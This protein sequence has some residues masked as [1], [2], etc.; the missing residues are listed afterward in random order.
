MIRV[1]KP[2]IAPRSLNRGVAA[3]TA[4]CA[5]FDADSLLFIDGY[6]SFEFD[7][8][9]YGHASV[10]TALETAQHGK[11]CYCENKFRAAA[12]GDVEH[13]R[14]KKGARQDK[15]HPIEHSGYYW[16]AYAWSNLYFSCLI[17]NRSG[18]KGFFPLADSTK[19]AR[20]HHDNI[21]D[22]QPLL[23]DPGGRDDPRDHI[24]FHGAIAKGV[25]RS[26]QQTVKTLKLNRAALEEARLTRIEHLRAL[27]T[28]IKL[29][30]ESPLAKNAQY[31]K[32]ARR[33]LEDAVK[34]DAI[35]SAMAQDFLRGFP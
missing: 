13:F 8:V 7:R 4:D 6:K 16:L 32:D 29:F 18:K 31:A 11:C 15:G 35:F 34:P 19:R 23:L 30:E 22:E 28:I 10:K 3:T 27:T 1:K 24:H 25:T 14:P 9:I 26:G 5:A 2:S 21:D 17:C 20:I 12:P 33:I